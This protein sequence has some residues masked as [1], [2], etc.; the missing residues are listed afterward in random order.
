[1]KHRLAAATL[2]LLMIGAFGAGAGSAYGPTDHP[3][4]TPA[5]KSTTNPSTSHRVVSYSARCTPAH[6]GGS[7][8]VRAKVLHATRGTSFTASAAAAF[9]TPSASVPLRQRGKS[10]VAVGKIPVPADQATGP[11]IVTVTIMYGETSTVL[12]CTSQISPADT[13]AADTDTADTDKPDGDASPH[14]NP[15]ASRPA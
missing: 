10:F 12:T 14:F 1:M 3:S 11:V 4:G 7:I 2:A 8:K 6:P 5:G 15:R 9:T 13:E